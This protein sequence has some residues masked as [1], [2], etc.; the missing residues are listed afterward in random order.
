MFADLQSEVSNRLLTAKQ[1][2]ALCCPND[3]A[4]QATVSKGMVFVQLYAAHEYSTKAMVRAG[5]AALKSAGTQLQSVRWELLALVLN[6][7]TCSAMDAGKEKAWSKRIEMFCR[8]NS[9]AIVDDKD[10][11]FPSDGSQ[12]RLSQSYLIWELFG[13][14]GPVLPDVRLTQLIGE[15]VE[16]RNAI[17]HGRSTAED[18]GRRY[19]RSDIIN[20]IDGMLSVCL[21]QISTLEAHCSTAGNLCR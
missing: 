16:H 8:A 21:Y 17:S 19:S 4:P 5:L 15:V 11:T 7:E 13:V 6:R 1:H 3:L 9:Q 10:E 18:I 2:F 20:K 14:P 12:F